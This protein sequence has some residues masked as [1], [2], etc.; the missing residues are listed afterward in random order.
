MALEG[1]RRRPLSA[2]A[3]K[4]AG[5]SPRIGPPAFHVM[6]KPR[7]PICNL[8][9]THC[10]YLRAEHL[11]EPGTSF[12]MTDEVLESF[13]RQYIEAQTAP[14]VTFGW[15]GGEPT[16]MGLDFFRRAVAL[17]EKYRRPGMAI[18]NALQTNGILLDDRWCEFLKAH[19]FLV[20]LSLDGPP[21]CHDAYRVDKGGRPTFAAAYRA[22][23]LLQRND[24]DYNVLCV[25]HRANADQPRAVYDFFR[26]E[27]VLFIQFIP[28][29]EPVGSGTPD[30]TEWT[31]RPKQ[32]GRFLCEV[33]DE[34]VRHDVARVFI[35]HVD[36]AL[37][38]WLGEEPP[39]CVHARTCGTCLA[40]EH[41]GDLFS[42]DHYVTPDYFLGNV[43]QTPMAELVASSFQRRF[44]ERKRQT[45]PSACRRCPV[46]F[47]CNG[48][49]QKD[50]FAVAPD[51]E[52]SL[53][54]LCAG[55][56][57]FFTHI[58]PYMRTM[59]SLLRRGLPPAAIMTTLREASSA[60]AK[61]TAARRRLPPDSGQY[62]QGQREGQQEPTDGALHEDQHVAPAHEQALPEPLFE[63]RAQDEG[64]DQGGHIEPKL[65]RHVSGYAHDQQDHQVQGAVVDTIRAGQHED[66]DERQQ[67]GLR[68]AQETDPHPDQREVQH[69]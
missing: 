66:D 12:R 7:G 58:D 5:E 23:K 25:V 13:T 22:L 65:P 45:L 31:V 28:A 57:Q 67:D 46:R 69:E 21:T 20:G 26:R 39:S 10:F 44:G 30:V 59:V 17:Q 42:C 9:C 63:K 1:A 64:H 62:Q 24:V 40:M 48:G 61:N 37:E 38:A 18:A 52:P 6:L 53:N 51:G 55:Y 3:V 60:L 50:R 41:N 8:N 33:F 14:A 68:D 4:M 43:M 16:L 34:W 27:G 36:G 29:V 32:W 54:Y 49:C 19:R 35:Q 2:K 15:Q 11:Y 47:A 56:N